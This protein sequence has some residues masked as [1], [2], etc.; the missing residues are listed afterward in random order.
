LQNF[1]SQTVQMMEP[2]RPA[3]GE[4]TTDTANTFDG[5]REALE[6]SLDHR[7]KIEKTLL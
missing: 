3:F 2:Q 6:D 1:F 5:L 4:S 7:V